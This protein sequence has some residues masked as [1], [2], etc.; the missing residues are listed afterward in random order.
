[1]TQKVNFTVREALENEA[2]LLSETDGSIF[3]DAWSEKSFLGSIQSS[4]ETVPVIVSVETGE[5]MGYAAV[6]FIFDE[7]NINRIAVC[8]KFRGN[9]F[10][11]V[12]LEWIEKR[13]EPEVT[14]FNLEVRESN[15]Y[16]IEMYEKFGYTVL[17][18]RKKFYRN[19]EEDALLMTKRKV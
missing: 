5:I 11:R 12:L 3:H 6:S 4:S 18:S 19:P 2:A 1:M 8:E 15:K 9:G 13:L 16:A 17:G 14:V 10:G 7:A